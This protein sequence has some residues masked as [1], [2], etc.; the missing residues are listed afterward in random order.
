MSW[1]KD[2]IFELSLADYLALAALIFA[3]WQLLL[4]GSRVR[5]VRDSLR[6][7]SAQASVY[8]VLAVAPKMSGIEDQLE[9][10]ARHNDHDAFAALLRSYRDLA[11]ELDGLLHQEEKHSQQAQTKL[12][13][14]LAQVTAA[15]VPASTASGDL[16]KKTTEVR[17][18]VSEACASVVGLTARLRSD[19]LPVA[20]L[21]EPS[22]LRM[23]WNKV[24]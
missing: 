7:A 5:Q 9:L 1:L 21:P 4:V 24:K 13:D 8:N 14:S 23:L 20:A 10:A 22:V 19:L 17:R 15:K 3:I 16:Y 6:N 2:Q 11:A 18:S 12:Q